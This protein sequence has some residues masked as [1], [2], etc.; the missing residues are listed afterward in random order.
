MN[1]RK[2]ELGV[3]VIEPYVFEDYRGNYVETYNTN[4]Y[5]LNG[6]DVNFV[7]DDISTS[8]KNVLRG[9]HGDTETWKLVSCLYG[10][11]FLVVV[12]C[13]KSSDSYGAWESFILSDRLYKQILIPPN[14][15]NG[16]YILTDSAIFHYKQSTYYDR[17]K[18]FTY[19][20]NEPLFGIT[21]P[22]KTPILSER[23]S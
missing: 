2:T 11:F 12:N 1:I 18:Q 19:K 4:E 20:W 21:W 16:H 6:I 5:K 23:D 10:S 8:R 17:S 15:G 7:Q 3:W 22:T 14:F 9:I 13:D